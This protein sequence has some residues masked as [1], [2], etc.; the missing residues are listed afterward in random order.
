MTP[1]LAVARRRPGRF[2]FAFAGAAAAVALVAVGGSNLLRANQS[3]SDG[4]SVAAAITS[5]AR[6]ANGGAPP[7]VFGKAAPYSASSPVAIH[8]RMS[9]VR[10]TQA[11][12]VTQARTLRSVAQ[13][14]PLAPPS[15]GVGP[16][17]TTS[18]LT[19]CLSAI[20]A[21][22]AQAVWADLAFYEGVPAVIIV[23][24]VDG[25]PTAYVVG[26][27]CSRGNAALVRPATPLP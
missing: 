23:A 1:L 18:G 13:T 2:L 14:Q 8:I 16:V 19:D 6:E 22:G 11:D 21:G 25:I 9:E 3:A 24:T 4:A 5:G 27:E 20:G 10:Y 26:H 12:F 17:G 7:S 15:P